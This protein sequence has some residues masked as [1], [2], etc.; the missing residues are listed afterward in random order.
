MNICRIF[1]TRKVNITP[2]V[3]DLKLMWSL[4]CCVIT[5]WDG[6]SS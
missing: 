3:S 5:K 6:T 4:S 2:F 1:A